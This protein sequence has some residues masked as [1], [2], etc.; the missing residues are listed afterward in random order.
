MLIQ[1]NNLANFSDPV[2]VIISSIPDLSLNP[3]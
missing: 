1:L 3:D 2:F